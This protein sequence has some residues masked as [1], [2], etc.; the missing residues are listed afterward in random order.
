MPR[1]ID[2]SQSPTT[3]RR[4]CMKQHGTVVFLCCLSFIQ[5]EAK[6]GF[7]DEIPKQGLGTGA[8]RRQWRKQAGGTSE[9]ARSALRDYASFPESGA[10]RRQRRKQAGG[11]SEIARSATRD[12]AS[13]PESQSQ[14]RPHPSSL[15]DDTFP[16][17]EGL[18]KT[19]FHSRPQSASSPPPLQFRRAASKRKDDP[20]SL[21]I[22]APSQD[23][24]HPR[25]VSYPPACRKSDPAA[26]RRS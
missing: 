1:R 19:Q 16:K 11:T 9:I 26:P 20:Q 25:T 15:R 14:R 10:C 8:C 17:G 21:L 18:K 2:P 13:F 22:H 23:L 12:Y 7:G 3:Q 5:R 6:K 4:P 24:I